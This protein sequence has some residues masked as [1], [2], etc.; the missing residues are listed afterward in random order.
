[1][2][3]KPFTI[4]IGKS[5][6]GIKLPV[7]PTANLGLFSKAGRGSAINAR[8]KHVVILNSHS[9][10]DYQRCPKRYE[11]NNLIQIE[12]AWR[13]NVFT[14]G[15]YW[16]KMLE[17]Y[18]R[19]KS[20]K[21]SPSVLGKLVHRMS[22]CAANNE[23]FDDDQKKLLIAQDLLSTRIILYHKRYQSETQDVLGVEVG[24]SIILFED[25]KHLFIYEG[26]PDRII[27][28]PDP[29]NPREKVI[30]II[31]DKTRGQDKDLID[32]NNQINGYL[33]AANTNW[34]MYNYMGKQQDVKKAFDRQLVY[35]GN[36]ELERWK[37]R[38]I[39]W[40]RKVLSDRSNG[41]FLESMQCPGEYSA[42]EFLPLCSSKDKIEYDAVMNSKFK[43]RDT[44]RRSW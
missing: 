34:F 44:E 39:K 1:M 21:A 19:A 24:F 23:T 38:T 22:K 42:C 41:E 33:V 30:C 35:R 17:I 31:D 13:R 40:Y 27:R 10:S 28:M 5:T 20:N 11:F 16:G 32:F 26:R 29:F 14:I 2:G 4:K 37:E 18:Y 8:K 7:V 9:L 6:L 12:P 3:A 15:A 25:A 43:K 36:A